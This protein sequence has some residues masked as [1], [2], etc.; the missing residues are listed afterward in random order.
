MS[1]ETLKKTPKETKCC[2]CLESI[3]GEQKTFLTI[4]EIY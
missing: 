3:T 1:E 2:K 4:N